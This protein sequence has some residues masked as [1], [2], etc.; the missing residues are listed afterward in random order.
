[1]VLNAE[2][3]RLFK[4]FLVHLLRD[5]RPIVLGKQLVLREARFQ[6]ESR[7]NRKK[8]LR[9]FRDQKKSGRISA[10]D[11]QMLEGLEGTSVYSSGYASFFQPKTPGKRAAAN[12]PETK[13]LDVAMLVCEALYPVKSSLEFLEEQ[14]EGRDRGNKP[15]YRRNSPR[16]LEM[17]LRDF[18][19]EHIAT[20]KVPLFQLVESQFRM[21]RDSEVARLHPELYRGFPRGRI[22]PR[23]VLTL[24]DM[25]RI[26]EPEEKLLQSICKLRFNSRRRKPAA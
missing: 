20:G 8:R 12:L 16:S 24:A 6:P 21:F 5:K 25:M 4:R 11:G 2:Q 9:P 10:D 1:M 13:R 23:N 19:R 15:K 17:L 22:P 18:E 14:T 7:E 26:T 3:R